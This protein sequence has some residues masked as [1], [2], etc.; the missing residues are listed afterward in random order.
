MST[1]AR[2][3]VVLVDCL[4]VRWLAHDGYS[5]R[6]DTPECWPIVRGPAGSHSREELYR[7]LG[8]RVGPG[9]I[10]GPMSYKEAEGWAALD[11]EILEPRPGI[12][13]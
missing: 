1:E 3:Y 8:P 2:H 11:E 4:N 9:Q 10:V 7:L 12:Y 6:G 5:V 13:G